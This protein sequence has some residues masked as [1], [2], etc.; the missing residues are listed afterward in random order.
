MNLWYS[1]KKD[2]A[3]GDC[4]SP[5]LCLVIKNFIYLIAR[6]VFNALFYLSADYCLFSNFSTT[7]R[8]GVEYS[9]PRLISTMLSNADNWSG[10]RP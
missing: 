7:G 4:P 2:K 5:Y 1:Y 8:N 6:Y 9:E 3:K 10:V